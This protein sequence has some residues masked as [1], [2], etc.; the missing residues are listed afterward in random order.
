MIHVL[1]GTE[2]GNAELV[3][4]DIADRIGQ[5]GLTADVCDMANIHLDNLTQEHIYILIC[6]TYGDGELP[7]SA[8]P[9]FAQ[10]NEHQ[11]DLSGLNFA[12]FGL[13]DSYYSTF[14][15][16]SKTME[17]CFVKLNARPIAKRGEHD[18]SSGDIP[19]D[20]ALAWV[21]TEL[22]P[23]LETTAS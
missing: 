19:T 11:P 16:G 23:A 21:E 8:Q 22:L 9:F 15:Q 10:L 7:N 4:E 18:A 1:F 2:T 13:G 14:N 20:V 17:E 12:V 6:S 5:T 3:A